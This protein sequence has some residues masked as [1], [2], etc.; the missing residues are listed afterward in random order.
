MDLC[1]L[2]RSIVRKIRAYCQQSWPRGLS[3]S[4]PWSRQFFR[5]V[6]R[7]PSVLSTAQNLHQKSQ[8]SCS[9]NDCQSWASSA[10]WNYLHRSYPEATFP[11][12]KVW[13]HSTFWPLFLRVCLR[14]Y[15]VSR[16][17][18]RQ[19]AMYSH[20]SRVLRKDPSALEVW[21]WLVP[22]CVKASRSCSPY[23]DWSRKYRLAATSPP[24]FAHLRLAASTRNLHSLF[25]HLW[26]SLH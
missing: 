1:Q 6:S 18:G 12:L 16:Q 19:S 22:Q 25:F 8:L 2:I 13:H 24:S 4:I 14:P 5:L 15:T 7:I 21:S 11:A 23:L 3:I 10:V 17:H 26:I 20:R 9:C